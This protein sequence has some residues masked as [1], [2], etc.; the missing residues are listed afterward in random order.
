MLDPTTPNRKHSKIDS[1]RHQ[2]IAGPFKNL[3][4]E[5]ALVEISGLASRSGHRRCQVHEFM[6]LGLSKGVRGKGRKR[7]SFHSCSCWLPQSSLP[8]GGRLMGQQT[9]RKSDA[10][11]KRGAIKD[12]IQHGCL[13]WSH[14]FNALR[15]CWS[16]DWCGHA[17][18]AKTATSLLSLC[19]APAF[20]AL[21][22]GYNAARAR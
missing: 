6:D 10:V 22:G 5:Q 21:I 20:L 1:G 19:A 13:H 16:R 8:A 15:R 9:S 18:W 17:V 11:H 7:K 14:G 4:V 2:Q 3:S 12:V